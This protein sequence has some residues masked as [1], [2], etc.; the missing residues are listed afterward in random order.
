M[1]IPPDIVMA[2]IVDDAATG[3]KSVMAWLTPRQGNRLE[4]A[5]HLA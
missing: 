5:G 4:K 2:G 3:R 1:G